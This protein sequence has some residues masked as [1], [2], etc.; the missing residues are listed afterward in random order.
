MSVTER[1]A[2]HRDAC[3]SRREL[4]RLTRKY[5]RRG[6]W[7][8]WWKSEAR[9]SRERERAAIARAEQER[10]DREGVMEIAKHHH[11]R[12]VEAERERDEAREEAEF[13]RRESADQ[14]ALAVRF[15]NRWA[16]QM[17]RADRYRR[18]FLRLAEEARTL[19]RLESLT[20]EL[21]DRAVGQARRYR[22]RA[23][24]LRRLAARRRDELEHACLMSGRDTD[25]YR[26]ALAEA[27]LEVGKE[28]DRLAAAL[29][30]IADH[31][32]TQ[33]CDV[34]GTADDPDDDNVCGACQVGDI[35]RRALAVLR[36]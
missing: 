3:A 25:E 15:K 9:K 2:Y 22:N 26:R 30:R 34:G 10:E 18:A 12:A 20:G 33:G 6:K 4:E 19:R 23:M 14:H 16:T 8:N 1:D 31:P 32:W 17:L 29:E 24:A 35:A 11:A 7:L 13:Y 36:G 21:W 28:R 5:D 27:L